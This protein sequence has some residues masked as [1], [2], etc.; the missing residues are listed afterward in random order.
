MQSMAAKNPSLRELARSESGLALV[1]FALSMP[2][3]MMLSV[4]FIELGRYV[5][6]H[7][8]VSQMALSVADNTGRVVQSIDVT[9]VDAAMIG[10]RIAGESI[11]FAQ[12]ALSCP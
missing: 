9:D 3:L 11:D 1:E 2:I 5:N 6:A 4:G 10:A 7:T 8:R 12:N